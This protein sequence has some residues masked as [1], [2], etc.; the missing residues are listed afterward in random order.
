MKLKYELVFR[1]ILYV[2]CLGFDS[3][4]VL[5]EENVLVFRKY[6]LRYSEV[7]GYD[8]L[9]LN[10]QMVQ[11]TTCVCVWM[12]VCVRKRVHGGGTGKRE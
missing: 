10:F 3:Y 4:T 11:N 8:V 7:K 1:G 5:T 9:Q 12:C 6:T 2:K